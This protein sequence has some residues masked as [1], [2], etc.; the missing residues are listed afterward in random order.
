LPRGGYLVIIDGVI[1]PWFLE[2]FRRLGAPLSYVALRPAASVALA[3]ATGRKEGL[4]DPGPILDLHRQF[5]ALGDL[6]RCALD[7]SS[8]TPEETLDAVRRAMGSAAFQLD[9]R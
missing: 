5:A 4:A 3:R 8:Q 7:T 2:P 6:E 1:G 9:N